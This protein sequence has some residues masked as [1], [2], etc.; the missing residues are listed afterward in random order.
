MLIKK[1]LLSYLKWNKPS[2][3]LCILQELNKSLLCRESST[4]VRC[5]IAKTNRSILKFHFGR[6]WPHSAEK[7]NKTGFSKNR[8]SLPSL[9]APLKRLRERKSSCQA[10]EI[11]E[12]GL[13]LTAVWQ[14][15]IFGQHRRINASWSSNKEQTAHIQKL[16]MFCL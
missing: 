7:P 2:K 13:Y 6:I 14:E 12:T 9:Q 15:V 4:A 5:A 10:V 8:G 11:L 16:D 1:D 3:Y